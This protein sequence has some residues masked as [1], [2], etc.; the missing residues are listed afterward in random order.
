MA[1]IATSVSNKE[2]SLACVLC[3][4]WIA[5]PSARRNVRPLRDAAVQLA[6][7]QKRIDHVADILDGVIAHQLD[8]A[9]A[10]SISSSSSCWCVNTVDAVALECALLLAMT[11][12]PSRL[13]SSAL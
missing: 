8:R 3:A 13:Y 5:L 12:V 9:G 10:S 1:A 4:P 6:R 7:D 2:A 11:K